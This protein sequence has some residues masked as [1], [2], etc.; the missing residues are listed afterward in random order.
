MRALL[1]AL[2]VTAAMPTVAAVDNGCTFA[3]TAYTCTIEET[4]GCGGFTAAGAGMGGVAGVA[5]AGFD[6]CGGDYLVASA[7]A[8]AAFVNVVWYG[9]AGACFVTAS[10]PI[11]LIPTTIDCP[12]GARPPNP[13]W[14][15]VLP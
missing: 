15:S 3:G 2:L 7:S 8:G 1:A 9:D 11:F 6:T 13:G 4:D 12:A 14:G 5:F 10:I